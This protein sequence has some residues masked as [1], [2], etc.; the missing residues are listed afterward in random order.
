M[1]AEIT[2]NVYLTTELPDGA[3]TRT[4]IGSITVDVHPDGVDLTEV[5][6]ALHG[7]LTTTAEQLLTTS[8][9]DFA[10]APPG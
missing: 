1:A 2:S 6:K 4:E 3:E 10:L 5:C 7:L 9:T 8:Q